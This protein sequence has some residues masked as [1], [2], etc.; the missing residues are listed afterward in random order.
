M[1]LDKALS[2]IGEI[3]SR[4]AEQALFLGFGPV[5]VAV[6]GVFAALVGLV[7][8][9]MPLRFAADRGEFMKVWI[10]ATVV[11]GLLI[12]GHMLL[13]VRRLHGEHGGRML[14][15]I[16]EQLM[17]AVFASVVVT[18]IFFRFAPEMLNM[19]PGLWLLLASLAVF[20]MSPG[21][22]RF[23]RFVAFWYFICGATVLVIGLMQPDAVLSPWVMAIPFMVGQLAMAAALKVEHSSF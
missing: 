7:Q 6:S 11:A 1:D 12:T 23:I 3:R 13:R 19:L 21:L 14:N 2:E 20:A 9:L 8:T 17:P 22:G 4:L 18:A 5:V 10:L 16:F 15:R